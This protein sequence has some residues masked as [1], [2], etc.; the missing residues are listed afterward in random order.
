MSCIKANGY[1]QISQLSSCTLLLL[2]HCRWGFLNCKKLDFL[3]SFCNALS[4]FL[5]EKKEK[6]IA[7]KTIGM[8]TK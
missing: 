5:S 7:G 1:C 2:A 3:F 6:I 8:G 4:A